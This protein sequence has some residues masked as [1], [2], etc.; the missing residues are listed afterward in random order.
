MMW[1]DRSVALPQEYSNPKY[2]LRTEGNAPSLHREREQ[3]FQEPVQIEL[4]AERIP[5]PETVNQIPISRPRSL[6]HESLLCRPPKSRSL[7][8]SVHSCSF[9]IHKI[10]RTL[11]LALN[12]M[13]LPR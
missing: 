1:G 10:K 3:M 11:S 6:A 9:T 4:V 2:T 12:N 5:Y 8:I 13:R 7:Q